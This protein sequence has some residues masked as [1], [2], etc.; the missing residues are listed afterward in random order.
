ME[1]EEQRQCQLRK[2]L[3]RHTAWCGWCAKQKPKPD[4][5]DRRKQSQD[6]KAALVAKLKK[7]AK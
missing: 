3:G 5:Q 6:A 4:W 1:T 7:N 2:A